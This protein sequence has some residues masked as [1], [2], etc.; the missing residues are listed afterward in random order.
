[1]SVFQKKN[2]DSGLCICYLKVI[3]GQLG[4]SFL[5]VTLVVYTNSLFSDILMTIKKLRVKGCESIL[6]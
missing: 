6:S 3:E 1:M 2:F 5:F 4:I